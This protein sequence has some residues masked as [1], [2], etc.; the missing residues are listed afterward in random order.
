[1]R[2]RTTRAFWDGFDRLPHPVQRQAAKAFRLWRQDAR[3]PS[4]AVHAT[5]PIYSVRIARGYRALDG[6]LR[7][8]DLDRARGQS[9]CPA[10][11]ACG[12]RSTSSAQPSSATPPTI[13]R[14][15]SHDDPASAADAKQASEKVP[16]TFV[17]GPRVNSSSVGSRFSRSS[18]FPSSA[19]SVYLASV[20]ASSLH[21]RAGHP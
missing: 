13:R 16:D 11:K 14:R 6:R 4:L 21:L 12:T 10:W 18:D 20:S 8:L 9:S 5:Q 1:M 3:H 15:R 17:L 7:R 19:R 2:S